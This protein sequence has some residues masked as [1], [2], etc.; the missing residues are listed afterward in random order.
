MD[1][2]KSEPGS[3]GNCGEKE[4]VFSGVSIEWKA[5]IGFMSVRLCVRR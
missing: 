4:L 1:S 2:E 5:T 3:G